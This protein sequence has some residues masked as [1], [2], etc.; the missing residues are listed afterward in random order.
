MNPCNPEAGF[1][2]AEHPKQFVSDAKIM[3]G[4]AAEFGKRLSFSTFR[5]LPNTR[6]RL[7]AFPRARFLRAHYF[8]V[9]AILAKYMYRPSTTM[10]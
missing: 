6:P 1:W 5:L 10:L 7:R 9:S 8:F 2:A 3:S 4:P